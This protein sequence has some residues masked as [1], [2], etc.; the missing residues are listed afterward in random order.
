[1]NVFANL[2]EMNNT[3]M[4]AN[5][6]YNDKFGNVGLRLFG[7]ITYSKNKIIYAD[8][9][10]RKYVYQAETGKRFGE[11]K[12]YVATG[13]F[14]GNEEIANPPEQKFNPVFPG[15]VRHK[16]LNA[17][18][19]KVIDV[20]DETYLG[21]SWFPRWLYGAGFGLSYK[22]FDLSI[23][24]QGVGDVGIMANGSGID[25]PGAG[26]RGAGVIPFSGFGL[27]PNNTMS[28]VE[29]RWTPEN[30]RQDTYYPRLTM[31][32]S[33]DNN[34]LNSTHGLKDGAYTRLKQAS[35][36]YNMKTPKV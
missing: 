4:D 31:A 18:D 19:D 10:L 21:K 36:R 27:Y 17:T 14:V 32:N 1:M 7:N 2:G 33:S 34:Y 22:N 28:I 12:S 29:D 30:P 6:E 20:F 13:Y 23:F 3:G 8:A 25:W 16:N 5:L 24:F 35:I 11:Y 26:S 9:P 15:D